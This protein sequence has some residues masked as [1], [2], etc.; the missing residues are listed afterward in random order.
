MN[1]SLVDQDYSQFKS[2]LM[3]TTM[4]DSILQTQSVLFVALS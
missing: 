1:V 3:M 4:W 2:A